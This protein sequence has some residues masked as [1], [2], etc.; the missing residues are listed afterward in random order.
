M[1]E[2]RDFPF[3][4]KN[5][6]LKVLDWHQRAFLLAAADT[7]S[8]Y[9]HTHCSSYRGLLS[10]GHSLPSSSQTFNQ[11]AFDLYTAILPRGY[12]ELACLKTARKSVL[13]ASALVVF[14]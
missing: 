9:K 3:V 6:V 8:A 13:K 14:P 1:G 7:S 2:E 12:T 4:V 5:I 11:S 10:R